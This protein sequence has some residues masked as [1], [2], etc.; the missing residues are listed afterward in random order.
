MGKR[1]DLWRKFSHL[2]P[3]ES[4]WQRIG[5]PKPIKGGYAF[6]VAAPLKSTNPLTKGGTMYMLMTYNEDTGQLM[7]AGARGYTFGDNKH[8][9]DALIHY[10]AQHARENG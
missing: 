2:L 9:R 3:P 5:N 4:V 10:A 1:I 7:Q 8:A 6:I